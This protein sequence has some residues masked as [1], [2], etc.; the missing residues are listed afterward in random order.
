[1]AK[2]MP[3][4]SVRSSRLVPCSYRLTLVQPKLCPPELSDQIDAKTTGTIKTPHMPGSK[5]PIRTKDPAAGF[6]WLWV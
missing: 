5:C 1:M 3:S 6:F 4:R 2:A